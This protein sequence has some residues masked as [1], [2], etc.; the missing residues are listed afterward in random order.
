[1]SASLHSVGV[2]LVLAH[3]AVADSVLAVRAG[4]SRTNVG[5][6]GLESKTWVAPAERGSSNHSKY[7]LEDNERDLMLHHFTLVPILELNNTEG[8]TTEDEKNGT[9]ETSEEGTQAP[10]DMGHAT[11]AQEADDEVGVG[12]NESHKDDQLERE[13]SLTDF[14]SVFVS[15]AL[16][17][18]GTTNSLK[19]KADDIGRKENPHKDRRL[20]AGDV[21]SEV[22]DSFGQGDVDRCGE[23]DGRNGKADYERRFS[24]LYHS[25][26]RSRL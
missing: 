2:G 11:T 9:V 14:V 25:I 10:V 6:L 15:G 18:D 8:R 21:W 13:T 26:K 24:Q 23:E 19:D 4:A 3:V 1:M 16:G 5:I 17:A 7:T 20:E 22:R 12:D